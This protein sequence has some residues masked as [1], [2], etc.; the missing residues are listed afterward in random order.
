MAIMTVTAALTLA[1]DILQAR[2]T[3]ARITPVERAQCSESVTTLNGILSNLRADHTLPNNRRNAA[4]NDIRSRIQGMGSVDRA[5]PE[6]PA[7]EMYNALDIMAY[8]CP[9]DTTDESALR[10]GLP[11]IEITL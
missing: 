6:L 11:T 8:L 5:H 9:R 1:R 3:D 10:D 4:Y 2:T 7:S